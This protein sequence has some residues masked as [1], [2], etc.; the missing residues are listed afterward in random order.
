ML[1]G[2]NYGYESQNGKVSYLFYMDDLK[3]FARDDNQQTGLLN[4]VKTFSDDIR[5]EFD[6]DKCAKATFKSGRLTQTTNIDLDIDTVIKGI[7]KEGTYKYLGVN[8]GDDIQF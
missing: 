6:L 8:E 7:E 5:M 4:I 3:T 1:N 2:S